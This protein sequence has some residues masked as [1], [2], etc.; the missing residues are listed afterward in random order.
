MLTSQDFGSISSL[1]LEEETHL[2]PGPMLSESFQVF[3]YILM[4]PTGTLLSLSSLS[5]PQTSVSYAISSFNPVHISL[6]H[7]IYFA[8]VI[9]CFSFSRV[10]APPRHLK[11]WAQSRVHRSSINIWTISFLQ[12]DELQYSLYFLLSNFV[13]FI[14]SWYHILKNSIFN[15]FPPPPQSHLIDAVVSM[16]DIIIVYLHF[17]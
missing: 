10:Q 16:L 11:H 1:C 14:R 2:S 13:I 4:N 12:T 17:I 5:K 6:S 7:A 8:M 3:A 9:I 15:W